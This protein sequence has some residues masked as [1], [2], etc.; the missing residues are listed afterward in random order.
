MRCCALRSANAICGGERS[1]A[2]HFDLRRDGADG[3][4]GGGVEFLI[5]LA[6]LDLAALA[7]LVVPLRQAQLVLAGG[8]G[9]LNDTG[10]GHL[11]LGLNGLL[12]AVEIALEKHGQLEALSGFAA[13]EYAGSRARRARASDGDQD[14][15]D[16]RRG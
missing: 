10:R 16:R 14:Q 2:N 9:D 15:D 12:R 6:D 4:T 7:G 3:L 11:H 5:V 1:F 13:A 8:G